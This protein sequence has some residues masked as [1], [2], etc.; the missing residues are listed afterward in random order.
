MKRKGGGGMTDELTP[1][2]RLFVNEYLVDLNA[3]QAAIRAGYKE[4]TAFAT[5]AENLKKPKIAKAIQE[6][7]E[8]RE[9]A[10]KHNADW[11]MAQ[12]AKIAEDEEI[13][14]RDR[15][16]ALELMGKRYGMWEKQEDPDNQSVR[17]TFET[18]IQE[19]SE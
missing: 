14:P 10:T 7:R 4:K 9:K 6:A 5:G 15:L 11:I 1:K 12:I 8:S 13:S 16:K 18:E 19:W 3:T 2:Q 17:V